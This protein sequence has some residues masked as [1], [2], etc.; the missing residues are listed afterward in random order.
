M[1]RTRRSAD[2]ARRP[3]GAGASRRPRAR[4]PTAKSA[5]TRARLLEAASTVLAL[6][7]L[8]GL[9]LEKVARQAGLTRGCVQYYFMTQQ[10]LLE[11][12]AEHLGDRALEA[13]EARA[14]TWPD[15]DFSAF[16]LAGI[17]DKSGD[18]DRAARMQLVAAAWTNPALRKVLA[19][20]AGRLEARST[21]LAAR[22]AAGEGWIQAPAFAAG[23]DLAAVLSEHLSAHI[24]PDDSEGRAEGVLAALRGAL[25]VLWREGQTNK[26]RVRVRAASAQA[27]GSLSGVD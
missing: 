1:S 19:A 18:R 21:A 5:A 22:W 6:E 24:W 7:G 4:R 23:R 8:G 16:T 15:S 2:R 17:A 9:S 10:D 11:A 3:I 12:L 20:G 27:M 13:L 25:A 26:P 14:K